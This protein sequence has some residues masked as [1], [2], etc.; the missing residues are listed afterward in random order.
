[1]NVTTTSGAGIYMDAMSIT[2][3]DYDH[4]SDMDIFIT[5]TDSKNVLL[6]NQGDGT[7]DDVAVAAGVWEN[8]ATTV[9]WGALFLDYDNNTWD[10]LF[11]GTLGTGVSLAQQ[12]DFYINDGDGTFTL[13]QNAVGLMGAIAADY[14]SAMGDMN[15]DG[16]FDF[17]NNN[18]S[19]SVSALW[20][21]DGG[22]NNWFGLTVTGVIS[23]RDAIGT[24]IELWAGG[25]KYVRYT[26]AGENYMCQN[27]EREVFGLANETT[28]DSLK[29]TWPSGLEEWYYQP[30]IN[31]YHQY[32]EGESLANVIVPLS[33]DGGLAICP[34]QSV[35]ISIDT[36]AEVIWS[37]DL[38]GASITVDQ[39]GIY[40]ATFVNEY[41][42]T[43]YSDT[44]TVSLAADPE[45]EY[46]VTNVSCHNGNN[47]EAAVVPIDE[48][49]D[50]IIWNNDSTT[51]SLTGL[52]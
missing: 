15:N 14:T 29:L 12:C 44:L 10:D 33:A 7:F 1:T 36:D 32:V 38:T 52:T 47:G 20:Q 26:M 19:P 25:E 49:L 42:F 8:D 13:N 46:L 37:N 11:V 27:S 21:N 28:V 2:I 16:Y 35:T 43:M 5:N 4:D 48:E 34:G 6:Q 40:S 24:L 22:T 30:S 9:T 18:A 3:E 41:G 50:S 17:I 23:N 45:L 51:F 31:T 39:P